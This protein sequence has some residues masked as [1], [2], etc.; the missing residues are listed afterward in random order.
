MLD[1]KSQKSNVG[2]QH[3]RSETKQIPSAMLLMNLLAPKLK[4]ICCAVC[5]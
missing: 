3:S 5:V 1:G 4:L 2:T